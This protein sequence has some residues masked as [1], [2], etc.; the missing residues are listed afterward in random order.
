MAGKNIYRNILLTVFF[1]AMLTGCQKNYEEVM[2]ESN[3]VY[4]PTEE[5]LKIFG[6]SCGVESMVT[7]KEIIKKIQNKVKIDD[8]KEIDKVINSIKRDDPICVVARSPIEKFISSIRSGN[9]S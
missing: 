4:F 6:E 1:M 9:G 2:V 8:K 5:E 3:K 7:T